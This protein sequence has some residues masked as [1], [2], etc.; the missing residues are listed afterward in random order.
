MNFYMKVLSKFAKNNK[1]KIDVGFEIS[2]DEGISKQ[3]IDETKSALRE[4][5]LNDNVNDHN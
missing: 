3:Q 5:G 2:S 4:L 1:L